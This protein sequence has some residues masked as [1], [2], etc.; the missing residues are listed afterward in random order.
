MRRL[1]DT[2]RSCIALDMPIIHTARVIKAEMQQHL[3]SVEPVSLGGS[4]HRRSQMKAVIRRLSRRP[5]ELKRI[6]NA[7]ADRYTYQYLTSGTP[8]PLY[9]YLYGPAR[10]VLNTSAYVEDGNH[11]TA[12]HGYYMGRSAWTASTVFNYIAHNIKCGG[13][14]PKEQRAP[15]GA[16]TPIAREYL[17]E[18]GFTVMP[19]GIDIVRQ[20]DMVVI[21]DGTPEGEL[22]HRS[23]IVDSPK[24]GIVKRS[25]LRRVVAD[26]PIRDA[27]NVDGEPYMPLSAMKKYSLYLERNVLYPYKHRYTAPI[28]NSRIKEHGGSTRS[29]AV[30]F[31]GK[32]HTGGVR[33]GFEWE[34][35]V[36]NDRAPAA[37][38][39]TLAK[40]FN[41]VTAEPY[42]SVE[43]D[44]S[45]NRGFELVSSN[46]SSGYHIDM[47]RK[48]ENKLAKLSDSRNPFLRIQKDQAGV[49]GHIHI[50]KRHI[51]NEDMLLYFVNTEARRCQ[52]STVPENTKY[53]ALFGRAPNHYCG[54]TEY[55]GD[56]RSA[57]RTGSTWRFVACNGSPKKTI[58]LRAFRSPGSIAEM[59]VNIKI[60]EALVEWT[61]QLVT[62][63]PKRLT[64]RHFVNFLNEHADRYQAVVDRIYKGETSE[65]SA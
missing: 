35:E 6:L 60:V 38:G 13:R 10:S 48:M 50:D 36:Y 2:F 5:E 58:E 29:K 53:A 27:I 24:F 44:S 19:N 51:K 54:G 30:R 46:T 33:I 47:L 16:L 22:V 55:E 62:H 15:S 14:P 21:Q 7:Q 43:K 20:A 42:I 63:N 8:A 18:L 41:T 59:I 32:R 49:G 9:D 17:A 11:R 31:I 12:V 37:T 39:K 28:D 52:T 23:H 65:A 45:L 34:M 26:L 61:N 57:A 3:I 4:D 40:L 56:V 25:D 1:L 64:M